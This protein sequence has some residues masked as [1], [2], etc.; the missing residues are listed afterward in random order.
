MLTL[1]LAP[2][3]QLPAGLQ[4]T[5][6]LQPA[7]YATYSILIFVSAEHGCIVPEQRSNDE[8]QPANQ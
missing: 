8:S 3:A 4:Q 5:G 1:L 2:S 6:S 7:E